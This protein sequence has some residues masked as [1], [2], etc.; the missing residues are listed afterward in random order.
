VTSACSRWKRAHRGRRG[1]W[2]TGPRCNGLALPWERVRKSAASSTLP[3]RAR[4]KPSVRCTLGFS[5]SISRLVQGCVAF[6]HFGRHCTFRV[7][8]QGLFL[9]NFS[10]LLRK[11]P[12]RGRSLPFDIEPA[13]TGIGRQEL[14][15]RRMASLKA[16]RRRRAAHVGAQARDQ[17]SPPHVLGTQPKRHT[18]GCGARFFS[19][20]GLA[21]TATAGEQDLFLRER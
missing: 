8:P 5:G 6:C 12:Q 17:A 21:A 13:E 19:A 16:L 9:G 14:G 18:R 20:L 2:H 4:V 3:A 15:S 11:F 10:R 7:D 1:G